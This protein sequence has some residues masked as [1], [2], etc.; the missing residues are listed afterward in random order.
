VLRNYVRNSALFPAYLFVFRHAYWA[1]VRKIREFY[2]P[3]V[4]P[5][6]LVFDIGA[7]RGVHTREFLALGARVVAVEPIP[8]NLERLN[9]ISGELTVLPVALADK[10]G[11]RE[12]GI[13]RLPIHHLH[14][15][16]GVVRSA[17]KARIISSASSVCLPP[18]AKFSATVFASALLGF[19]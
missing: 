15:G 10:C 17:G 16:G 5:G 14:C 11:D 3:F 19:P 1:E 6:S 2:R 8:E 13:F 7:N 4:K 12:I 18:S 9:S